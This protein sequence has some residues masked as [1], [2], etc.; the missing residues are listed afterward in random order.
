MLKPVS[1]N[2]NEQGEY[3]VDFGKEIS[4]WIRLS[5]MRGEAGQKMS[6]KYISESPLGREEYTFRGGGPETYAPRFTWYVFS[7]AVISGL[8]E[9]SADQVQAEAVNTDVP[10][11]AEFHTSNEL[12]NTINSIWQRSQLDNM[13]GCIASD[14]PHRERSP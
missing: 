10:L 11:N 9:L 14:C 4:G 2:R 5:D 13:H 8:K 7:K 1:L 6:V 3:E 12:F